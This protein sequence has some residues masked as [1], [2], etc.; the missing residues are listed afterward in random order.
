MSEIINIRVPREIRLKMKKVPINW[1]SEIRR[2]IEKKIREYE[3]LKLLNRIESRAKDRVV[4]CDSTDFIRE[5]RGE[6]ILKCCS[7]R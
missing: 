5:D 6:I 7:K 4:K 3:L 2:F 1:S